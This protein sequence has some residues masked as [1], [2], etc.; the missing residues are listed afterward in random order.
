MIQVKQKNIS[1]LFFI[2]LL[3]VQHLSGQEGQKNI[4]FKVDTHNFG[5]VT[6]KNKE[7]SYNFN[8]TNT[9]NLPVYIK[10]IDAPCGCTIPKWTR[11]TIFPNERGNVKVLLRA[12]LLSGY[13]SRGVKVFTNVSEKP[14]PLL[15]TG[16]ILRNYKY[17]DSFKNKAGHLLSNKTVFDFGKVEKGKQKQVDIKFIN[18]S[19]ID[20]IQFIIKKQPKKIKVEQTKTTVI[21][22]GNS[23]ITLII[24]D[25]I[26]KRKL[27][28]IKQI[29]L[30]SINSKKESI[31][32][33][34]PIKI[35]INK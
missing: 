25:K 32:F 17:N 12:S 18:N 34:I 33:A 20:T 10:R 13:F 27:R 22:G 29:E 2:L 35:I 28:K 5:S 14:I 31:A 11:D 4:K 24:K 9:T 7:L 21:P 6:A 23:M 26:S 8:F 3:Y 19:N 1:I 16:R 15:V 30:L